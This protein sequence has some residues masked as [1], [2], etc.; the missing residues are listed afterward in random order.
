MQPNQPAFFKQGPKPL[1]QFAIYG[2]ISLALMI[3]DAQY[4]MLGRVREQV[5][6]ILYPL[7]WLATAPF[8]AARRSGDFLTTQTKL[9]AENRRLNDAQL[10]AASREFQLR[11]LEL[12][13]KRLRELADAKR[14]LPQ[15]GKLVEVLYNA[16]DPFAARL[17]VD[18]GE[19]AGISDGRIVIDASG[20]VG[21]IVRTQPLT[22]EVQLISDHNHMVPVMVDRN[23]LRTVVYGMGRHQPLEVRNLSSNVDIQVGDILRT[24]GLDGIYP[25]G[26]PV[27]RISRVE[28]RAGTSFA[29]IFCMPMADIDQHRFLLVLE[30]VKPLPA[31]PVEAS[32]PQAAPK[33]KK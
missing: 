30:P 32:A 2:V 7:Q 28:R 15:A 29:R 8:D 3:G 9:L 4:Q 22:S 1:T 14:S 24:S 6:V 25:A 31:Y 16:R 20:V 18:R 21:Q 19:T 17:I 10:V 12:E 23:Q 13:N 33:E 26:L 5:S 27:A 11:Q